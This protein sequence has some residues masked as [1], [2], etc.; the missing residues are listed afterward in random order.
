VIRKEGGAEVSNDQVCQPGRARSGTS[1]SAAVVRVLEEPFHDCCCELSILLRCSG[2][3]KTP[4][5]LSQLGRLPTFQ[6]MKI[7]RGACMIDMQNEIFLQKSTKF[8]HAKPWFSNLSNAVMKSRSLQHQL[9]EFLAAALSWF[10]VPR[11]CV[12]RNLLKGL[13]CR[14]LH[15]EALALHG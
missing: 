10:N 9:G 7:S 15:V 8:G 13:F 12:P 6:K 14:S 3:H 4:E 5:D 2:Q 11:R 1:S